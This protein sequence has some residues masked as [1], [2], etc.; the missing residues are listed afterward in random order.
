MGFQVT[1]PDA[2]GSCQLAIGNGSNR[3]IVGNSDFN[4]GVGTTSAKT[5]LQVGAHYGVTGGIGTFTA[6]A[7]VGNAAVGGDDV[8][9]VFD[10]AAQTDDTKVPSANQVV[11]ALNAVKNH[12]GA[13]GFSDTIGFYHNKAGDGGQLAGAGAEPPVFGT[14][15][16][17]FGGLLLSISLPNSSREGFIPFSKS[18][19]SAPVS[20]SYSR[21]PLAIMCN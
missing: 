11:A 14:E 17:V 16:E 5:D 3:W 10:P 1:V 20:V 19:I 9:F 21:R 6:A 13:Q 2:T 15:G 7:G 18:L 12:L 8:C 4:V